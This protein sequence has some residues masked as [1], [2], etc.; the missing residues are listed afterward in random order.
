MYFDDLRSCL[1][2]LEDVGELKKIEGANWEVEIG[3]IT[4]LM[5]ARHGPALL[6]DKIPG[7]PE[8]NRVLSNF[9]LTPNRQKIAFGIPSELSH[10]EVIRYWK[11]KVRKFQP[12][13]TVKVKSGPVMENVIT[14]NDVD[15]LKIPV[16]K[17]HELDGGRYIGTGD[18]CITRDPD[19]GWINCGTYRSMVHDRNTVGWFVSPGKHARL[20]A[21]KYWAKGESCPIV[22]CYGQ[23]PLL[24]ALGNIPLPYGISELEMVGWMKGKGLEVIID[25]VTGLP[26]P[27]TAE[28]AVAGFSPPPSVETREEG[29]FGEWTGYY[30]SGSRLEPVIKIKAIYHRNNPILHGQPPPKPPL[31]AWYPIP[32]HTASRLWERLEQ[33][34]MPGIQGVYVHGPGNRV[35]PVVSIKQMYLGHAKQIAVLAATI[36]SGGALTG[37]YS[38]VVDEDID[39]SNLEEVLWAICTRC[40]P[41][42]SIDMIRGLL[43]SALDVPLPPEKRAV[44]NFTA[45]K[46][47]INACKPFHWIKD[48]PPVN[49]FS[50]D[51]AKK[52]MDKWGHVFG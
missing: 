25:D 12:V 8:G 26:I 13:P 41:E 46:V 37:R 9:V 29:P 42:S 14:G 40:D 51:L 16:P 43:T 5:G 28:I 19:E 24:F 39:P 48:F 32:I 3:A 18:V 17:W 4:E 36:L 23:D 33:A 15:I 10:V 11:D 50:K 20:M 1:K 30:A 45:A 7:Y 38:I 44:G 34:G 35:V 22:Y 27:A 47:I 2:K 52:V 49:T 21:Q 6:F 31:N